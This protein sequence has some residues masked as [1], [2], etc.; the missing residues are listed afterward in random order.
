[1]RTQKWSKTESHV[2]DESKRGET[3]GGIHAQE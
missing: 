2:I 1:M 3:D